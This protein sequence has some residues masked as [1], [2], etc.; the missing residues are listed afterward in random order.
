M[1]FL[2]VGLAILAAISNAT[3]NVLQR[4]VDRDEPSELS[5]SPRLILDLLH[6]KVWLAG[7]ATVTLSFILQAAALANGE[8]S[9]VQPIVV[10]ELPLT[11]MLASLVYRRSLHK[12]EWGPIA[13]MTAGLAALVASLVPHGGSASHARALEWAVGVGACGA[14]VVSLVLLGRRARGHHRAGLFGAATGICFGLTAAFM[15]A[16]TAAFSAGITGVLSTWP[17][18]ATVA[19]GLT[20]MFLMQNALQ[21]GSLVAA[22]PGITILDPCVAIVW[23]VVVFGEQTRTGLFVMAAVVGAAAVA[24]GAVLLARSPL[25]EEV[26]ESPDRDPSA[27]GDDQAGGEPGQATSSMVLGPT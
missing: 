21:A 27:S 26:S 6:H 13:L 22:Q 23:G 9:L 2:S 20:G 1:R 5:M 16:A 14:V 11:L 10:L 7:L 17:T 15:K 24:A 8:L 4:T 3:S 19:A 25:L 12:R 18:Y